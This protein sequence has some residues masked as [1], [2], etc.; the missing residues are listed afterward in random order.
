MSFCA[1]RLD[2]ATPL[3]LWLSGRSFGV[4][5]FHPVVLVLLTLGL[6][7]VG[8]VNPFLNTALLTATGLVASFGVADLARRVPGV[9]AFL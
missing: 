3:S 1:R 2:R 4:Y 9:R 7:K 6:R 8:W 5:L